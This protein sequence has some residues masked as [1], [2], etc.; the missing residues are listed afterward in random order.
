MLMANPIVNITRPARINGYRILTLSDQ[1]AKIRRMIAEIISY[2]ECPI[3]RIVRAIRTCT[4]VGWD[5]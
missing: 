2:G 4:H 3:R 1:T 5:G